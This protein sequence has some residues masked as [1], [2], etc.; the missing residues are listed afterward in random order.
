MSSFYAPPPPPPP[1]PPPHNQENGCFFQASKHLAMR[2]EALLSQCRC[3]VFWLEDDWMLAPQSRLVRWLNRYRVGRSTDAAGR[4]VRLCRGSLR[5][6]QALIQS[7]GDDATAWWYVSL[8]SRVKVSL[9]PSLWS[10]ALFREALYQPLV[11]MADGE[12]DDPEDLCWNA[13]KA[14][15]PLQQQVLWGD[16]LF[17]DV[18]HRWMAALDLKKWQRDPGKLTAQGAAGYRKKAA[19]AKAVQESVAGFYLLS[20]IPFKLPLTLLAQISCHDNK[21][22]ARLP[23]VPWLAFEL[24]VAADL[25]TEIYLHR[26]HAWAENSRFM[27]VKATPRWQFD[28]ESGVLEGI[29]VESKI[30]RFAGRYRKTRPLCA[31]WWVPVQSLLGLGLYLFTFC[32]LLRG[33]KY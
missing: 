24:V 28:P 2:A 9:N 29:T 6:K 8:V 18:G 14:A 16:P 20:E 17:Q 26:M 5:E 1:P 30:G 33:L 22:R 25:S 21:L 11:R 15:G 4:P 7:C 19:A 32:R 23:G 31:L 27:R 13:L 12:I 3:G 10:K